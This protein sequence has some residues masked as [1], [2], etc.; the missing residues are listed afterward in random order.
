[1]HPTFEQ[2]LRALRGD[3]SRGA[4]IAGTVAILVGLAWISWMTVA[5]VPVFRT[6]ERA[7]LEVLPAPTRVATVAA[8]RVVAV[9]L[10]VG[11][12]VA[13]GDVLVELDSQT[14]RVALDRARGQLAALDPE[15]ASL[16]REIAAEGN[17]VTAGE[18]SGRSSVREQ[19]ARQ[20]AADIELAHAEDE[21]TRNLA[22]AT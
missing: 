12:R 2:T 22:M 13:I 15:L 19:L 10:Q 6:S 3:R 14:E 16:E 9:H 1:M 21:L 8:G 20:R 18:A 5:R 7:R 11:A 17:A 4:V